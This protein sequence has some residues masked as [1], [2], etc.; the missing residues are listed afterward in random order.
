[1]AKKVFI[2]IISLIFVLS[3]NNQDFSQ[4]YQWMLLKDNSNDGFSSRVNFSCNELN[5]EIVIF[6][7]LSGEYQYLSDLWTSENGITWTEVN[8][9]GNSEA[10]AC[11]SSVVLDN[12]LYIIGGDNGEFYKRDI[13]KTDN[14]LTIE[15][16]SNP[17]N[18]E[19]FS[20]GEGHRSLLFNDFIWII[21]GHY[22]GELKN[23]VWKTDDGVNLDVVI[24]E[25][26]F[27]GRAGHSLVVFKDKLWLIGGNTIN[28]IKNDVWSSSDGNEWILVT[29]SPEFEPRF[30][31]TT[32]TYDDKIWIVAGRGVESDLNDIWFSTDG[33]QWIFFK[34]E[35]SFTPRSKHE[36]IILNN[37]LY[38]I[39]G[40][41][42]EMF[43]NDVWQLDL[44][45]QQ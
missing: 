44:T 27:E 1:M 4:T 45:I 15:K 34:T 25:A 38:I 21:G 5:N 42:N 6:G 9:F 36:S 23:D 14:L 12:K 40:E 22:G 39:G 29:A 19:I 35:N 37:S 7:G 31:H 32:F 13:W 18:N 11:H 28:G 2:T 43:F 3:C 24:E 33:I 17:V 41:N 30:D 20:A 8:D 16:L 10:R 26:E